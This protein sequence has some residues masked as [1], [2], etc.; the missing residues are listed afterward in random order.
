MVWCQF[1]VFGEV[2]VHI[3]SIP[4]AIF[5][6]IT[7]ISSLA[8]VFLNVR[9]IKADSITLFSQSET[10]HTIMPRAPMLSITSSNN[11]KRGTSAAGC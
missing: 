2:L 8:Q 5:R 3:L 11:T 10:P 9:G 7:D 6:T 4:G 1:G